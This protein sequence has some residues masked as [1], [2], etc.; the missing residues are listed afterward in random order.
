MRYLFGFLCVCALGVMPLVGCGETEERRQPCDWPEDAECDD[1]N[2]CTVDECGKD[3]R[4]SYISVDCRPTFPT[5]LPIK[6]PPPYHPD[7]ARAEFE[8]CDPEAPEDQVCGAITYINE[9]KRCVM[10]SWCLGDL[11]FRCHSGECVCSGCFLFC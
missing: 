1:G 11:G 10:S 8:V 3:H 2:T 9:G 7:C 4:C 5:T 6:F